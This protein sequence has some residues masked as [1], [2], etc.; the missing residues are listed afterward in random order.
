MK[1]LRFYIELSVALAAA[2]AFGVHVWRGWQ[3]PFRP[4]KFPDPPPVQTLEPGEVA[5]AARLPAPRPSPPARP[6]VQQSIRL[7]GEEDAVDKDAAT[8]DGSP[9]LGAARQDRRLGVL[10][11]RLRAPDVPQRESTDAPPLFERPPIPQDSLALARERADNEPD[12]SR[13]VRFMIGGIVV[14]FITA[15]AVLARALRRGRAGG[16][17]LD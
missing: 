12:R 14:L 7:A 8:Y 15:Y 10:C 2:G 11:P 1:R 3:G 16:H 9:R 5:A 4:L 6:V 13:D 17:T